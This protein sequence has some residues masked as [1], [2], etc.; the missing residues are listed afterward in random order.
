MYQ[1][2]VLPVIILIVTVNGII[3]SGMATAAEWERRTVKELLLAPVSRAAVVTGKMLAGFL[4][5]SLLAIIRLRAALEGGPAAWGWDEDQAP[6]Q[7]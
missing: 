3:V 2:S 1:Y 6:G 7:T 5:T 4:A